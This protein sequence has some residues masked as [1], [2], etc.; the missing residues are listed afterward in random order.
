MI[1]FISSE[2]SGCIILYDGRYLSQYTL[3]A[4]IESLVVRDWYRKN[5][6]ILLDG[7][8]CYGIRMA[9]VFMSGLMLNMH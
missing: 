4:S 2:F 5:F 7:I 9:D 6:E 8:Y 3:L 1:A